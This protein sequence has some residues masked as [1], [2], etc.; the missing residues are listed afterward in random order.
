MNSGVFVLS[1]LLKMLRY[2]GGNIL[3]TFQSEKLCLKAGCEIETVGK[4]A[5]LRRNPSPKFEYL[6]HRLPSL[7]SWA[8]LFGSHRFLDDSFLLLGG[9]GIEV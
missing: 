2:S 6:S 8:R 9:K 3:C 5:G 1:T 4:S 7:D